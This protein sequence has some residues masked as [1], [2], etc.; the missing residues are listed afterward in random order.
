MPESNFFKT[1]DIKV[2]VAD[3]AAFGTPITAT[4]GWNELP[5][6]SFTLPELSAP[7]EISAARSGALTTE[8]SQAEHVL[9]NKVYTFD[10]TMKGSANAIDKAMELLCESASSPYKLDG[11]YT[12]PDAY[13]DGESVTTQKTFLFTGVGAGTTNNDLQLTSVV[14]TGV[15]LSES[16]DSENGQLTCVVN[17]M[18]AY[19]PA[20]VNQGLG[21]PTKLSGVAKNIKDLSV[22]NMN[23]GSA[24]DLHIMSWELSLSRSVERVASKDYTNYKPY[25]YAMV[26]QW[27]V[28]GSVTCKRDTSIE[29]LL[30]T[31][32]SGTFALNLAEASNFTLSVPKCKVNE[33][34]MDNGGSVMMQTIPF[35]AYCENPDA[36]DGTENIVS[37]TIA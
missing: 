21:T 33:A 15:T 5:T 20:Y 12:F 9:H 2:Y 23:N 25:G 27:E 37:L 32:S 8:L 36:S 31:L 35:T 1:S 28:T 13:K 6:T 34:T 30:A 3:E 10:V 29:N 19:K 18:T 14:A 22:Y 26:G 17:C 7:V 24:R 11:D 4:S 16:L